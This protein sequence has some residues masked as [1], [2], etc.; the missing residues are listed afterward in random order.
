M[1]CDVMCHGYLTLMLHLASL[2]KLNTVVWIFCVIS[3]SIQHYVNVE[4]DL[5]LYSFIKNI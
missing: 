4:L 3:I 2:G 1:W 5:I